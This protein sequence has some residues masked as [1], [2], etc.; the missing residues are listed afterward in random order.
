[1]AILNGCLSDEFDIQSD[2][3]KFFGAYK[4]TMGRPKGSGT[5]D[6][7]VMLD[8]KP[9]FRMKTTCKMSAIPI[10][11]WYKTSIDATVD[12]TNPAWQNPDWYS[13]LEGTMTVTHVEGDAFARATWTIEYEKTRPEI[14]DPTF[15]RDNCLEFF[16]E[17]DESLLE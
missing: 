3:V 15:I 12:K 7:E 5:V 8:D 6:V 10:A 11:E 14:D 17:L 13:K 2:E 4:S 16:T 1:M 9:L